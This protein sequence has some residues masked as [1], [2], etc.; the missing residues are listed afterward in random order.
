MQV[1]NADWKSTE[2]VGNYIPGRLGTPLQRK[3][4]EK[5]SSVL[6]QDNRASAA[7]IQKTADSIGST[8]STRPG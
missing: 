8:G 7:Y 4:W 6:V 3:N 5:I 1:A 2:D